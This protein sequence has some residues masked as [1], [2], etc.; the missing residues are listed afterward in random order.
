MQIVRAP[1]SKVESEARVRVASR[2]VGERKTGQ[3]KF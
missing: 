1:V 3:S 2:V